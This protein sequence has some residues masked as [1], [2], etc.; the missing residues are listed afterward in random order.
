ERIDDY[1]ALFP[2]HPDYLRTFND[3][4]TIEK[5]EVLRCGR[6]SLSGADGK[7]SGRVS[8]W[9]SQ[10]WRTIGREVASPRSRRFRR[11]TRRG[12]GG[13]RGG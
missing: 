5:R 13:E 8:S 6:P 9:L 1:V 2:V 7:P 12:S 10:R 4:R 11:G 3:M